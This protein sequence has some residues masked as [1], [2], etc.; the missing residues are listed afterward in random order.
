MQYGVYIIVVI[1]YIVSGY[2]K[3]YNYDALALYNSSLR[4]GWTLE[5]FNKTCWSVLRNVCCSC[6]DINKYWRETQQQIQEGDWVPNQEFI[7]IGIKHNI[8]DSY[9]L[10]SIWDKH[11]VIQNR[12][13]ALYNDF[14]TSSK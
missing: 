12:K 9:Q 2:N 11:V 4:L 10:F 13:E 6:L 7:E 14:S 8:E 1:I 5:S 3:K